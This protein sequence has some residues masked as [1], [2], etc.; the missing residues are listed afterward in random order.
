MSN[1][2]KTQH[3]FIPLSLVGGLALAAA[4]GLGTAIFRND[5]VTTGRSMQDSAR[6]ER[7]RALENR[8]SGLPGLGHL[9]TVG[10]YL[11]QFGGMATEGA[12]R[13]FGGGTREDRLERKVWG[14]TPPAAGILDKGRKIVEDARR[15]LVE[16]ANRRSIQKNKAEGYKRG[17]EA[18][19]NDATEIAGVG[20]LSKQDLD[21]VAQYLGFIDTDPKA[22][23]GNTQSP[24]R[25]SAKCTTKKDNGKGQFN[26]VVGQKKEQAGIDNGFGTV[27]GEAACTR[28]CPSRTLPLPCEGE[29]VP[30]WD[31]KSGPDGP[32]YLLT[33]DS[34]MQLTV[35]SCA[36]PT[37]PAQTDFPGPGAWGCVPKEDMTSK[38]RFQVELDTMQ[39]A[40]DQLKKTDPARAA[41]MEQALEEM[42]KKALLVPVVEGLPYDTKIKGALMDMLFKSR[43]EDCERTIKALEKFKP[44][45]QICSGCDNTAI[46][47]TLDENGGVGKAEVTLPGSFADPGGRADYSSL[48]IAANLA[49]SMELVSGVQSGGGELS[50][51]S[52][53]EAQNIRERV[54]QSGQIVTPDQVSTPPQ[55]APRD[56]VTTDE[57][58]THQADPKEALNDILQGNTVDRIKKEQNKS[59]EALEEAEKDLRAA[60]ATLRKLKLAD[61]GYQDAV[62]ARA[63]G[64][65]IV[66]GLKSLHKKLDAAMDA[67]IKKYDATVDDMIDAF[68]ALFEKKKKEID[69][70]KSLTDKQK[71]DAKRALDAKL[72]KIKAHPRAY[73]EAV[74]QRT[75]S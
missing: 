12:G 69:G 5:L 16:D 27:K 48:E 24:S 68:S 34:R 58:H 4:L 55:T 61:K 62:E 75:G 73:L 10:S 44:E 64:E 45:I 36:G 38:N 74:G 47:I 50:T 60:D 56:P 52:M 8:K 18:E 57:T 67:Q 42:A 33:G 49:Q 31:N 1:L 37:K 40:I 13:L 14:A 51:D 53:L 23:R 26:A 15:K 72:N 7:Q 25:K 9:P 65:M 30:G 6:Q 71:K 35:N 20:G 63:E 41:E 21:A 22:G 17:R 29:G 28:N 19:L 3:G 59:R 39:K 11:K 46:N 54:V 2:F 43:F 66:D 70:D 32:Y